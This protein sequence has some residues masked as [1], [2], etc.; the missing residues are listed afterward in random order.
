MYLVFLFNNTTL[1]NKVNC[2]NKQFKLVKVWLN[3]NLCTYLNMKDSSS[4][5]P[6]LIYNLKIVLFAFIINIVTNILMYVK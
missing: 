5:I 4:Y 6:L 1:V 2:N 3:Y